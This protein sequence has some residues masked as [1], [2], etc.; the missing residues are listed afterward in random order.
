MPPNPELFQCKLA[1]IPLLAAEAFAIVA[2]AHLS[3]IKSLESPL[4]LQNEACA[5]SLSLSL[6]L[7]AVPTFQNYFLHFTF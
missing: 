2:D 1:V 4:V 7:G 3:R 6:S 5:F